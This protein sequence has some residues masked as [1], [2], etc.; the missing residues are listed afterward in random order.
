MWVYKPMMS[1]LMREV[2][3]IVG[4]T[5]ARNM[6]MAVVGF[7]TGFS[8]KLLVGDVLRVM[9]IVRFCRW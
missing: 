2:I 9:L 5:L 1:F 4:T 8:Q 3:V 6:T 7:T